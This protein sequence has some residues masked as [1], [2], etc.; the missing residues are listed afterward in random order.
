MAIMLQNN[1]DRENNEVKRLLGGMPKI[2]APENFEYNLMVR[3]ENGNF[4]T[5]DEKGS[6]G[7]YYKTLVPAAAMALTVFMVFFV[8]SGQVENPE[9][10]LVVDPAGEGKPAAVLPDSV[11]IQQFSAGLADNRIAKRKDERNELSETSVTPEGKLTPG[12]DVA[13]F[14]QS[15]SV[16][17][18]SY[19]SGEKRRPT[20]NGRNASLVSGGGGGSR[21]DGFLYRYKKD[22]T[23]DT[24]RAKNDS[25]KKDMCNEPVK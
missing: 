20:S 21:F 16:D 7:I 9:S 24:L 12:H 13:S 5:R 2:N 8:Y 6:F 1:N 10:L 3:I 17:L 4:K 14:D 25:L 19:I 23:V 22:K 15:K 11:A 18:D